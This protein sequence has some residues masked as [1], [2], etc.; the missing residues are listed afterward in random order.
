ME[1]SLSKVKFHEDPISN[2]YM[3]SLRD[4][5]CKRRITHILLAVKGTSKW[6]SCN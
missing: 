5:H 4:K 3:K 6:K 2:F 1:T